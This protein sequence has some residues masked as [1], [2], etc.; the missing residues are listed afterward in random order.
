VDETVGVDTDGRTHRQVLPGREFGDRSD[1]EEV[2][3]LLARLVA[4]DEYDTDPGT[5]A[6]RHL[7]T[8]LRV[9]RDIERGDARGAARTVV[10]RCGVVHE[11]S[12]R[13]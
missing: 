7:A 4:P 3:Y 12:S 11:D 8:R 2:A 1:P 13:R 10:T 6:R 5:G 9:G